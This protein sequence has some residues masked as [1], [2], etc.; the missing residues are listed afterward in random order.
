MAPLDAEP[1][2]N[3]ATNVTNIGKFINIWALTRLSFF[4]QW[5]TLSCRKIDLVF[6]LPVLSFSLSC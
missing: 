6:F 2:G 3:N 4:S 5:V 1:A